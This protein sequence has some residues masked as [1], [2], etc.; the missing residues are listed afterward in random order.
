MRENPQAARRDILIGRRRQ[1]RRGL[2]RRDSTV[3]TMA[4]RADGVAVRITGGDGVG[5]GFGDRL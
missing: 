1:G 2:R 4:V 5:R 3:V